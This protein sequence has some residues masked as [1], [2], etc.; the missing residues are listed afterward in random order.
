M[1]PTPNGPPW[2]A[3]STKT[4][5][6]PPPH[7]T[8]PIG[9]TTLSYTPTT[10]RHSHP[11]PTRGATSDNADPMTSPHLVQTPHNHNPPRTYHLRSRYTASTHT[12]HNHSRSLQAIFTG[13]SAPAVTC[14]SFSG[15]TINPRVPLTGP[16]I[17]SGYCLASRASPPAP[18]QSPPTTHL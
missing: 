9:N 13:I 7:T 16:N 5:T 4:N 17:H 11:A 15:L 8:Q 12:R 14:Y 6:S 3:N 18:H 1:L 2:P 10:A